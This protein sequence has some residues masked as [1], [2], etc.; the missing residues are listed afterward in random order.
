V[1]ESNNY[2]DYAKLKSENEKLKKDLEKATTTNTVVF[3]NLDNDEEL[4]LENEKLKEENKRLK[5]E[6]S[7][8]KQTINESLI[9]ENKKLKLEKE[10]LKV[11]LR[12]FAKGKSLQS[13][14]L[15]N[16]VM[17][18]DRSGIDYLT[19]QEKK[20]KAQQQ[21][22]HKPKP[23]L[24]GCFECGQGGHFAHDC[25][26]PPP[27]PFPKHFRPFAFN[28]HYMLRK[29]SSGKIKVMF[30]GPPNKNRP[31]KI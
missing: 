20:V 29:N 10:H 31:K 11:G 23:K 22:Q 4:T 12:K 16:T 19:N 13:D 30:L 28:A 18:M 6:M 25:E 14:L 27:Q 26:T 9:K 2:D 5:F 8:I 1:V 24:K 17:K 15:M 21:Q 7:C 3:E